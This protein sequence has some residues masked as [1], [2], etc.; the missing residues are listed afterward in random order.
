MQDIINTVRVLSAE[1]VEAA[2][3]GHPGTPLGISP[4]VCALYAECMKINPRNVKFFDRDRFV[5]SSGHASA[6][7]Y[8]ILHCAGYD[9]SAE[10]LKNF[11]RYGS[12]TPGHPEVGV[13]EGVDC[14]TDPLGQG[15]ANAVGM[16]LAEKML[17]ARY[18]KPDCALIDHYTYALCGGC[19]MEGIENEAAGLAAVWGL[20]KLI[21]IYDSNGT[22][23]EGNTDL[24]LSFVFSTLNS[25]FV[26]AV[27]A[28]AL[29]SLR[30]VKKVYRIAD[31]G[32][33]R[34]RNKLRFERE[35]LHTVERDM[36]EIKKEQDLLLKIFE[37]ELLEDGEDSGGLPEKDA[38]DHG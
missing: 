15:V 21:L 23:I 10:D 37:D 3:S 26:F 35:E 27:A 7:L 1:E 8:A 32:E 18:N 4:V 31:T 24:P 34:T 36:E 9:V 13:T 12:K 25:I 6:M 33:G 30:S 17:A 11:R 16:A 19:M 22:T 29:L 14:S 20:G 28:L 38:A 5:L 2:G